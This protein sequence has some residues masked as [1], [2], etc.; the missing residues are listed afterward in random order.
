MTAGPYASSV[1]RFPTLRQSLL[2]AFDECA[3][4]SRF[5]YEGR[6]GSTHPQARGTVFHRVAAKCFREMARQHE[7]KIEVDV[8]LTILHETLRQHDVDR[9]CPECGSAEIKRGL[10]A[11]AR[12]TC[13][14][15]G[16]KFETGVMNLPMREVKDLYMVTKKWAHDNEWDIPNLVS[17][18]ERL[19]TTVRYD[20]DE[21]PVE[22]IVTGQ[23][24]ALFTEMNDRAGIVLDHK[25]TWA[26]PAPTEVSF[27]GYFQQRFY[28]LLVMDAYPSIERATL[29][30]HYPRYSESREA[31]IM[32]EELEDVRSEVAA[33]VE[34]FDRSW[35]ERVF[36]PT[37]GKRCSYCPRPQSCPIPVGLRG[38][39]RILD[40]HEAEKVAR[41]LVVAKSVVKGSQAS[42][43]AWADANGP[44]PIKD[45]KGPRVLGYRAAQQTR[46]PDRQ[47]LEQQLALA[48]SPGDV[49]LDKLYKTVVTTRFEEHVPKRVG[50]TDEDAV[51]LAALEGALAEAKAKG[52]K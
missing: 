50:V 41:Q 26:L 52:G 13:A 46:R 29:R 19:R 47:V 7:S 18:E 38:P 9:R 16:S 35:H 12:R 14:D 48:S 6:V 2:S 31:T 33:L 45:A 30:E 17:V 42:L 4:S 25:D 11:K 24:D 23:L 15:C 20:S 37:A 8:A 10:D 49:D 21:G 5:E 44:V 28:A 3:L 40:S 22:R 43:Q 39:G 51:M 32:R 34:R 36:P 1:K 27:G